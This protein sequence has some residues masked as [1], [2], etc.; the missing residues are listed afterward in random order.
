MSGA[1]RGK[2]ERFRQELEEEYARRFPRSLAH[3]EASTAMLDG[4]SHAIRWNDPF[5]P[6]A[7]RAEGPA[8]VDLDGHHILDYWQGHFANILGHNPP[9]IRDALSGMLA[10]GGGLQSGMLHEIEGEVCDLI[11]RCTGS[12]TVRLTTSGSLAAFYA[13]L[14]ARSF[15]GRDKVLKVAGGWHG[16]QPFGLKGVSARGDSFDHMES[17]G[18]SDT[19][20]AEIVLTR[21]ND[22]EELRGAFERHGERLACFVLEPLLGAGGGMAATDEYLREARRLTERH[23][24]LLLCDEIITAFRFHAG[25][26]AS[27]YGVRPDLLILGKIL[28]GG[29]PVAAVAGKRDVMSLCTRT[30]GR[31]KFEGGTYSAHELS[32]VAARTMIRHLL[33]SGDE[34]YRKLADRGAKIREGLRRIAREEGVPVFLYGTP[35]G[36]RRESSVVMMHVAAGELPEPTCPEELVERGHPLIDER[37][38]KSVLLLEDLS[39]RSGLGAL[40]TSH[41]NEDLERSLQSVRAAFHRIKKAGL[42][43]A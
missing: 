32:L 34:I 25:D 37:L 5:M 22:V 43:L 36:R 2:I 14:L 20:A 41:T 18:L 28:G 1:A 26:L 17:E 15:T 19:T 16:S 3:F 35:N 23:G 9:L 21:F 6:V 39:T 24:A 8:I 29:M 13:V 7:V 33:D 31:V 40:S 27:L 4:A 30:S 11:C 12:E 42:I 38:L 10:A